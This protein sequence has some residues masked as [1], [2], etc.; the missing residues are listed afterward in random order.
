MAWTVA[1][2]YHIPDTIEKWFTDIVSQLHATRL[3][4]IHQGAYAP[5]ETSQIIW[6]IGCIN[7]ET[8]AMDE[9]ICSA[10]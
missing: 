10:V 7:C 6:R 5:Q 9:P 2:N 4:K 1:W 3:S 8:I